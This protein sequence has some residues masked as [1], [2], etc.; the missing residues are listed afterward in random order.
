MNLRKIIS[1]FVLVLIVSLASFLVIK[2][3]RKTNHNKLVAERISTFPSFSFRTL[4]K[5]IYNSSSIKEGPVLVVHF[6]PECEHCQ[7]EIS[8]ILK[9]DIPDSFSKV[10]L[11][12]AAHPDSIKNFLLRLKYTDHSSI[13]PLADTSY[14]FEEIFGPGTIPSSYVYAKNLKLV[15]VLHGEVKTETILKY[16][17]GSEY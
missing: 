13:L 12:S 14:N 8:E 11:V 2:I 9:S 5:T 7:Y 4:S 10:I 1:G 6:H 3:I 17:R 16:L 15:K